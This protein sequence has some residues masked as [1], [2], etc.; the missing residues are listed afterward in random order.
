MTDDSTSLTDLKQRMAAF[1]AAREWQKFHRPKNLAMS[2]AVE[3]AE[4]M[5][6]FQWLTHEEADAALADPATRGEVAD[7]MSD[8][9]AF[10][11]SLAN[12]TGI[13]LAAAFEAKMLRNEQKYPPDLVRGHYRRPKGGSA[14]D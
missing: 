7:E 13:D 8:V 10:L 1:V 5:E 4:L 2:M 9:L 11:L 12:C 3:A 6:H 14:G